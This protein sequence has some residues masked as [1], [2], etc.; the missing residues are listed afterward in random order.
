MVAVGVVLLAFAVRRRDCGSVAV[1]EDEVL[2]L[3]SLS[4][5]SSLTS[6]L[7]WRLASVS[8]SVAD[9]DASEI[10]SVDGREAEDLAAVTAGLEGPEEVVVLLLVFLI[11]T[12]SRVV[13][14]GRGGLKGGGFRF[15]GPEDTRVGGIF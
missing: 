4:S 14:E 6:S 15:V 1:G 10:V 11:D 2:L 7:S 9:E 13:V 3:S 12:E 8:V 5:L